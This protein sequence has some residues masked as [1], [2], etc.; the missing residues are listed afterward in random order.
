MSLSFSSQLFSLSPSFCLSLSV[1]GGIKSL[2]HEGLAEIVLVSQGILEG[3]L[4]CHITDVAK[5]IVNLM[6]L[7]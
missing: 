1:S 7:R 3:E 6:G 2:S 4:R 5:V